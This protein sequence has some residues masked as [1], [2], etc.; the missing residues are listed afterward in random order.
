MPIDETTM[1]RLVIV[2]QMFS[3]G[4][5]HRLNDTEIGNMLA[6]HHYDLSIEMLLKIVTTELKVDYDKDVK[7]WDLWNQVNIVFKSKFGNDIPLKAEIRP[8]RE[9]R[10][11]VQHSG[12]IPS[13]PDIERFES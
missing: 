6:C 4:K 11:S 13:T 9:A 3:H 2:K 7:F 1:K 5:S 8:L 12:T 10:N